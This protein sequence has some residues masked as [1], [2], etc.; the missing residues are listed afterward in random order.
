MIESSS[1]LHVK[2]SSPTEIMMKKKKELN[3]SMQQLK[4]FLRPP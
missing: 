3:A 4:V 1:Q 2:I